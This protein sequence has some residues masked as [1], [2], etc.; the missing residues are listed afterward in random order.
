M[1]LK[2]DGYSPKRL[3]YAL[4]FLMF[5]VIDQRVKTGS[6]LN[7]VNESFR[8]LTGIVVEAVILS[9]YKWEDFRRWKIPHMVW[10]GLGIAAG[11][12]LILFGSDLFPF[13]NDRIVLCADVWL[14]G[15]IL[16]RMVTDLLLERRRPLLD[17]RLAILWAVMM[18]WMIVSRN[19]SLWPSAYLLLFG[20]L[21]LT[22][23]SEEER[24]DLW[25][26]CVDGIVLSFVLFQG[27]CCIFRPYDVVRYIGIQ[28]NSNMNALYYLVVLGAVFVRI[29]E[30][31]RSGAA[32]RVRV[33][34]WL[35]AGAVLSFLFMTIGRIAWITAFVMGL[36]FLG[37]WNV[38]AHKK[39]FIRNG[40][41][42]ILCF[43]L[44]FPI[45]FGATRYL[46]PVFHHPVW[47]WGEWAEDKV[48]SWDPWDSDKYVDL[49]EFL[50]A[51]VGRIAGSVENLLEHSPLHIQARAAALEEEEDP[52]VAAAILEPEQEADTL[53]VRGII[54]RHYFE[55]LNWRGHPYEEQGFQLTR[56]YW[57]GHAHNIYLQYGTDFGIPVMILFIILIV[58]SIIRCGMRGGRTGSMEDIAAMFFAMIPAVFGLL[59]YAWGVG[60]L[61]ITMLFI[62]WGQALREKKE[63]TEW[64]G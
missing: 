18:L 64:N 39:K 32:K 58:W 43:G 26:G 15:H 8:D 33:I 10:S 3:L 52:R 12:G 61:S 29:I 44:M 51:A 24:R 9:H 41:L 46:P 31:T 5:A 22:D 63:D 49:D 47:L 45:C 30:L 19:G 6:G 35:M 20:C 38:V 27:F 36:A 62:A 13:L 57:I 50:E 42:L 28:S 17:K 55:R 14:W 2:S 60:S 25:Q 23:F 4:C 40:I 59:E 21:Y 54:Y 7:G 1:H 16:I 37:L 56:Y 34:W 53:L 48:H 11:V